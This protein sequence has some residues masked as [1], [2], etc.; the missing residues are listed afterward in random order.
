MP[1][2]WTLEEGIS[3]TKQIIDTLGA[4]VTRKP[5]V[6]IRNEKIPTEWTV[7][8]VKKL[9]RVVWALLRTPLTWEAI[10]VIWKTYIMVRR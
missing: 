6:F 3:F 7:E 4:T 2:Q 5:F 9:N 8:D 1:G 10:E